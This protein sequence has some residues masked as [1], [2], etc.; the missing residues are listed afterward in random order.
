MALVLAASRAAA[1]PATATAPKGPGHKVRTP[2][3]H[4]G[5]CPAPGLTALSNTPKP[6]RGPV[7]LAV[8]AA[9]TNSVTAITAG[10][11]LA[12]GQL[13]GRGHEGVVKHKKL[14]VGLQPLPAVHEHLHS[15]RALPTVGE[16]QQQQGV[17]RVIGGSSA[18]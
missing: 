16:L 8:T 7:P 4:F 14:H 1:A 6:T 18:G 3:P 11:W 9:L 2:T 5:S 13:A 17:E 15:L 12:A 10:G